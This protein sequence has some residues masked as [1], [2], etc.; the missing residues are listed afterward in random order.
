[1]SPVAS[2]ESVRRHNLSLLLRHLHQRGAL[3]RSELGGPWA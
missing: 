3:S 2:P 1:M